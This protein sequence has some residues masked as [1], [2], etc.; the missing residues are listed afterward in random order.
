MLEARKEKDMRKENIIDVLYNRLD[1]L[2]DRVDEL[3]NQV[4]ELRAKRRALYREMDKIIIK[5][6]ET[7]H[8]KMGVKINRQGLRLRHQ[9][10]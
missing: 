2:Y 9:Q 1:N 6:Q 4:D 7:G 8:C 5:L 3:Y 10:S